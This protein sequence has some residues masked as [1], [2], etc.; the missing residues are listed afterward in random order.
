MGHKHH[1]VVIDPTA[2]SGGS[3]VATESMLR[4]LDTDKIKITVLS[5]DLDSWHWPHLK[6]VHLYQPKWLAQQEQGISYFI[7]HI[8]IAI[9]I[10]ILRIRLGCIDI[11]LGASGPGVDLALYLLKPL[12]GLRII[13]LIHGPV[14][15]SKTIARCLHNAEQVFYLQSSRDSLINSLASLPIPQLQTLPMHFQ[16]MQNGLSEALWPTPCLQQYQPVVMWAASLLKWKGLDILRAA[17][18][19]MPTELRP[20][21]H[22]CYIKPKETKLPIS[23]LPNRIDKMNCH[24]N[25]TNLDQIRAASNIFISTSK[26]EPFGL[27]ILEAM[28]A[29]LCVMI[30]ADGAYWDKT[31][32]DQQ[33]CIKYQANNAHDLG[34]KLSE[35]STELNK[36]HKIGQ[37]AKVVAKKYQASKCYANIKASIESH[38]TENQAK[39]YQ[40]KG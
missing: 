27:S 23:Q 8:W 40:R 37:R 15:K 4:L 14:A 11:G 34:Q 18:D 26:N 39:S 9:N 29:G 25:P 17:L 35:L 12:L 38:S 36:V 33:N 3:K 31:L 28:A 5:A 6:R 24:Q 22:I 32:I 21:T 10:L 30:P 2:F 1:L 16:L 13:Q 19:S 20:I 7:R